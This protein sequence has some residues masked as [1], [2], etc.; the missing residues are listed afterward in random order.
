[1]SAQSDVERH[2]KAIQGLQKKIADESGK[3][4]NARS[5][6]A[7][8][9][10]QGNRSTSATVKASKQREVNRRNDEATAAEKRR[11]EF[12]KQLASKQKALNQA[13]TKL[14]KEQAANQAAAF[15]RLQDQTRRSE[16]QFRPVITPST[17]SH[18][19]SMDSSRTIDHD[20]FI[21]HAS[22]DKDE[23]ARPLA[24]MLRQ[25]GLIVWYDEFTL[26]VGDSLRR[27]IDKGLSSSRFG[28]VI[29]SP[30]FFQK[31]WPQAELDG[32]AAKERSLGTKVVLPIWH[33]VSKDDVLSRSPTLA[34][35]VA[36]NTSVMTLEQIAEQ[37]VLVVQNATEIS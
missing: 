32:L 31:E 19:D 15:K 24:A 35:R 20:V 22:E 13:E 25:R 5:R 9:S 1:M 26:S 18:Q 16:L 4:A 23:L 11:S 37:L 30:N 29:L 33:R 14:S 3:V 36:L 10:K 6:A 34:D 2:R 8:A 27:S 7:I 17:A 12:E 21:A 28:V